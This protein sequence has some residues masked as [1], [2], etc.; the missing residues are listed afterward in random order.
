MATMET[1]VDEFIAKYKLNEQA[2]DDCIE[3]INNCFK[4]YVDHMHR[5]FITTPV[6][7]STTT[8]TKKSKVTAPKESFENPAEA[9]SVE[10]LQKC[11]IQVLA[12]FC[13]EKELKIGGKKD[14]VV[15]RVW[16]F[17]QGESSDEDR[18]PKNR[19]KKK[20]ANELRVCCGI[21][22]SNEKCVIAGTEQGRYGEWYCWRH[23][24]KSKTATTDESASELTDDQDSS[25]PTEPKP[26]KTI[27]K[28]K[29]TIPL[30]L[31]EE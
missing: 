31:E 1:I 13:K 12:K 26:K 25:E 5:E 27:K 15:V 30:D 21:T 10:Q 9:E 8:V 4:A 20:P 2:K 22:K 23:F 7:S 17:L 11:T 19:P 14:E 6:P 18:T 16:R 24:E 29:K 28:S 3:V